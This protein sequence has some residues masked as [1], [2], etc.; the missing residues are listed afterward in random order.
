MKRRLLTPDDAN[1]YRWLLNLDSPFD[2]PALPRGF[3]YEAQIGQIL[4]MIWSPRMTDML[5]ID[6]DRFNMITN[7]NITRQKRDLLDVALT[8]GPIPASRSFLAATDLLLQAENTGNH[9]ID[10]RPPA[11]RALPAQMEAI[12]GIEVWCGA[13]T[14]VR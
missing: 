13:A 2:V 11:L 5:G 6:L 10:L 9:P 7:V 8:F 14:A 4:E 3:D 1:R 12:D